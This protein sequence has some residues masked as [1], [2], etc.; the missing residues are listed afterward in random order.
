MF[1]HSDCGSLVNSFGSNQGLLID[2]FVMA[3]CPLSRCTS[4]H[5]CDVRRTTR[6][7]LVNTNCWE[8][9]QGC[10]PPFLNQVFTHHNRKENTNSFCCWESLSVSFTLVYHVKKEMTFWIGGQ[11]Y[12]WPKSRTW[13]AQ[14]PFQTQRSFFLPVFNLL[15]IK[16]AINSV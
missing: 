1:S 9:G 10:S 11:C 7:R 16:A 5:A 4:W 14:I 13:N 8:T 3:S 15:I 6:R 12:P 2:A